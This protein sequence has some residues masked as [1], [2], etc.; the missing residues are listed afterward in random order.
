MFRHIPN[1]LTGSRLILA[2]VFF[3]L[4]SF[5]QYEGRGSPWLLNSAFVIYLIALVTDFLDGYLARR[6]KVE[7][8]FGRIVDP[9]VDKILVLGSFA[10]FAGKNF[11]IP[12]PIAEQAFPART[13]VAKTITGVVPAVVVIMLARELLVTAIRAAAEADG[14]RFGAEMAGKVKMVVQSVTILVILVYV[15]YLDHLRTWGIETPATWFR[16][17]CIWTTVAVTL[18]SCIGYIRR[19]IT[20]YNTSTESGSTLTES[21]STLTESGSTLGRELEPQKDKLEPQMNAVRPSSPQA[22]ERR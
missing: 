5:Y 19:A 22:D 8:M 14:H 3:A 4:L 10:F 21:G 15:A 7:G 6:W 20:L 12:D 17:F 2:I 18:L 13:F 9:F 11:I 1:A 16:D